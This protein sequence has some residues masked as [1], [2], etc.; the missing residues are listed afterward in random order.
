MQDQRLKTTKYPL[1]GAGL[2]RK[3]ILQAKQAEIKE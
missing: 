3:Q 1:K 2:Y